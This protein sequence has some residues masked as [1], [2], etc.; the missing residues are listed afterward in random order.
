[1]LREGV[2]HRRQSVRDGRGVDAVA[3]FVMAEGLLDV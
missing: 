2:L 3:A 1:V